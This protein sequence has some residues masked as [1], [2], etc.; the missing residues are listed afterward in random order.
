LRLHREQIAESIAAGIVDF[1]CSGMSMA[2]FVGNE[3]RE[4]VA[5]QPR[6]S[7]RESA[8]YAIH[9]LSAYSKVVA[10][11]TRAA[12]TTGHSRLSDRRMIVHVTSPPASVQKARSPSSCG[13]RPVSV[14]LVALLLFLVMCA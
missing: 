7:G 4:N 9:S 8:A 3:R 12:K 5:S 10:T 1:S 11:S 2:Q 13:G 6:Q 14:I